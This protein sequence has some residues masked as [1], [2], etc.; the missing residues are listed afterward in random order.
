M[1]ACWK[2]G[3]RAGQA[4]KPHL[5]LSSL[6]LRPWEERSHPRPSDETRGPERSRDWSPGRQQ[7]VG[8][9]EP[10]WWLEGLP[11]PHQ[12]LLG[13]PSPQCALSF[14]RG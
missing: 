7:A 1:C 4:A 6:Q 11:G 5:G 14:L 3:M 13:L 8:A 9:E 12:P 2:E 10:S